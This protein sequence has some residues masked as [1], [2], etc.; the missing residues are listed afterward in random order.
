MTR[1]MG[2][3]RIIR[4]AWGSAQRRA[5]QTGNSRIGHKAVIQKHVEE[6]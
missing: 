1:R 3:H 5:M 4:A 2:S 6:M